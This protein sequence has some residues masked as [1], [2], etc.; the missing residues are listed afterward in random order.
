VFVI[1]SGHERGEARCSKRADDAAGEGLRQTGRRSLALTFDATRPYKPPREARPH[2]SR[3]FLFIAAREAARL[4]GRAF[5][6]ST[7]DLLP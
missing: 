2:P 5:A 3:A 6:V 1:S 4:K 7:G